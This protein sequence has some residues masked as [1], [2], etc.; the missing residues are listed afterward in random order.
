MVNRNNRDKNCS[1]K[2]FNVIG[3]ILNFVFELTFLKI[4]FLNLS[5]FIAVLK[6]NIC[7]QS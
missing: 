4:T 7:R 2:Y 6:D 3:I 1:F 5:C